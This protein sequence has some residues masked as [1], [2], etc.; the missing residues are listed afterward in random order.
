MAITTMN[1]QSRPAPDTVDTGLNG[2]ATAAPVAGAE[3][4]FQADEGLLL[5]LPDGLRGIAH[6]AFR[7]MAHETDQAELRAMINEWQHSHDD[8]DGEIT[9][10]NDDLELKQALDSM[11]LRTTLRSVADAGQRQ[12]MLQALQEWLD[13]RETPP[14]SNAEV[15]DFI[16]NWTRING[17]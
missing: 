8:T 2:H 13:E 7:Q 12:Q 1:A 11:L 3:Q 5:S 14:Q 9:G 10:I 4:L 16:K 15:I 6:D 17:A